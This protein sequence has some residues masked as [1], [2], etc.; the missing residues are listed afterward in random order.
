MGG[1]VTLEGEQEL[2]CWKGCE[3]EVRS[4]LSRAENVH[5]HP[6]SQKAMG[7]ARG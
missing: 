5:L 1:L 2:Q 4:L 3:H 7:F 6:P